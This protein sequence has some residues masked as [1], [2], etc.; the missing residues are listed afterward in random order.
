MNW[1]L[2]I[3]SKIRKPY[4]LIGIIVALILWQ[5]VASLKLL[6]PQ[7]GPAFS[8]LSAIDALLDLINKG[9]LWKQAVPSLKRVGVGLLFAALIGIPVGLLIGYFRRIEMSTYAVFQFIRMISPLAW[10]PLAIIAFGIGDKPIYFL[11]TIA[12]IWP[13]IINTA[14]GTSQVEKMWL[15]LAHSMGAGTLT[16]FRKII[17]PAAIPDMLMGLRIALGVS[18]L[19]LVPAEMLGV[20]SGL[21]YYI[22]DTRDRFAYG[23]LMSLI[24]TIGLIG[25]VL[26]SIFKHLRSRYSW[27]AAIE[28]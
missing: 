4:S 28:Y 9:T 20:S 14:H 1:K 21:G 10:M 6:G 7:F 11:I 13:I 26:D 16:I 2:R 23:E 8:P 5:I 22:L 19:I 17:I 25:F 24:L 18:W 27:K 3:I 15:K 12:A